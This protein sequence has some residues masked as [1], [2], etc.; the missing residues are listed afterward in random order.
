MFEDIYEKLLRANR[1]FDF[2]GDVEDSDELSK[3]YKQFSKVVHPDVA[4]N[5]DKYIASQAFIKLTEHYNNGLKELGEGIYGVFDI[6]T[7]Y[8]NKAPLFVLNVRGKEYKIFEQYAEGDISTI[9]RGL[10]DNEI[11]CL[12]LVDDASDN[13]LLDA[14][15]NTLHTL[16]HNSLPFV[17]DKIK[18]NG[19][20]GILMKFI[21]GYTYQDIRNL[22]PNGL[23]VDHAMWILERMLSV[24]GF[25][26]SNMI[27]HGNITPEHILVNKVNHNTILLGCSWLL[28]KKA[29]PKIA[30]RVQ[31][32]IFTAPEVNK[33][34]PVHP[35]SDI[36]SIGKV[37]IALL[38]GNVLNNGMPISIDSRIRT[39]I[40][41]LVSE[42]DN[43]PDD[44]W[45][46]WDDVIK[47]RDEVFGKER[48]KP[49]D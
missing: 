49:L 26:H 16:R 42:K 7:I 30:Y 2:F 20:T 33:K 27:V 47:L 28:D 36:Y 21:E 44:A 10:L 45:K 38:G 8:R 43:R 46:L 39:F 11:I 41:T 32:D 35:V 4:V 23:I 13:K 17:Y 15:F 48:F 5:G 24:V 22:H 37:I 9:F 6:F 31:N 40:R 25:L 14:E 3:L 29:N 1:P 12:K 19:R 34:E 18:V